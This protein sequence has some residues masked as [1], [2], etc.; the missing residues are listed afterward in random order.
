MRTL[1]V[2]L[3]NNGIVS[4]AGAEVMPL[5]S[6]NAKS[7]Y[8]IIFFHETVPFHEDGRKGKSRAGGSAN[9]RLKNDLYSTRE[10]LKL[11]AN[12]KDKA[13]DELKTANEEIQSS[14][15]ELRSANEELETSK[16]EL[17]SANEEMTTINEELKNRNIDLGRANSDLNN[18][19]G[20]LYTPVLV[21]GARL[22]IRH[23]TPASKDLFNLIPS[24]IGRP[25]K[26]I[27]L[28]IDVPNLEGMIR[29]VIDSLNPQEVEV[30]DRGGKW[31]LLRV[32]PYINKNAKAEG[33][34]LVFVDINAIKL[35]QAAVV[36]LAKYPEQNPGPV[37]RISKDG[38]LIYAN[39]SSGGL[40]EAWGTKVN[41]IVPQNIQEAAAR[42]SETL[43]TC[44]IEIEYGKAVYQLTFTP[45]AEEGYVNV[46]GKDITT[47]KKAEEAL[48]ASRRQN[49]FLADILESSSQPFAIGY[50]DGKLGLMNK[51]FEELSGYAKAELG[52]IDWDKALTPAEWHEIER[53]KLE[54]LHKTG[55]SVRY[56]K[57]Y[58]RRDGTRVPVELLVHLVKDSDGKP[59]YYYS[60]VTDITG[61]KRVAEEM[62]YLKTEAENRA[63]E[64]EAT[65]SSAA[66]GLIIY[67][68]NGKALRMNKAA[69]D[70]LPQEL[71]FGATLNERSRKL[72]WIKENGQPFPPDEI[73]VARALRGETT[74]NVILGIEINGR[75][76][77]IS[78]SAA[79]IRTE[80]GNMLGVVAS[81][82]DISDQKSMEQDLKASEKSY[83]DLI[84]TANSIIIRYAPDGTVSYINDF[85]LAFFGYSR[86]EIVGHSIMKMVPDS[87]S[88][89]GADLTRLSEQVLNDPEKFKYSEN[90]NIKKNGERAWIIWANKAIRDEKGALKEILCVGNDI[91]DLKNSENRLRRQAEML[92]LSYEAIFAWEYDGA[93]ISWNNGA[94]QMYGYS[95][96]EALGRVSHELLKT[97]HTQ[98]LN[99]IKE[100]LAKDKT[101]AGELEHTTKDGRTIIVESR[102]QLITD[103]IGRQIVLETNRDITESKQAEEKLQATMQRFYLILSNMQ[104]AVLLV[105]DEDRVEFA[106]QAFCNIFSLKD[107]PES[108]AN[109]TDNEMIE[110]IKD[111]Y[112]DPDAALARIR[113]II[114]LGQPAIGE[115]V[116]MAGERTLLR[117]FIPI[118]F[119]D[120]LYGRLWVHLDITERKKAEGALRESEERFRSLFRGLPYS[121]VVFEKTGNDFIIKEYN[122]AAIKFTNGKMPEYVGKSASEIYKS[123]PDILE[124]FAVVYKN[125]STIN[126]EKNYRMNSTGKE[127]F[128]RI[129][130][131]YI[132]TDKIIMHTED[133]SER[134]YV[135]EALRES[136]QRLKFHFENSP[137]AVVEWDSNY[138]VTQWSAEAER[139][140]GWKRE[141]TIGKPIM[142]LNMIYVDDIP[143]VNRTIERLGSGKEPLVVS[144][145]RNYTKAGDVIECIWYNTVMLDKNGR[146]SSIMSLV[147]D[148]TEKKMAEEVLQRDKDTLEKL[149]IERTKELL[150]KQIELEH[151]RRLF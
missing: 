79:P 8:F 117:N 91:T 16:E 107:R 84:E 142:D 3:E 57:E 68:M 70:V 18:L 47:R 115:D 149:V 119:N 97:V 14:N 118:R 137:L 104:S 150:D 136:E 143:K 99:K 37:M 81:F 133:F 80:D 4:E 105:T 36:E 131:A 94:R 49:E 1:P 19:L 39:K 6:A 148:I 72:L 15:E 45:I 135:E 55:L 29:S 130:V 41:D 42:C 89:T 44:E 113:E 110:K 147:Q 109:L 90:Q 51:A 132:P 30:R 13:V 35:A 28:G 75:K 103:N 50:P 144:S 140:F 87:D 112:R 20:N 62:A 92:N 74:A 43:E 17:Q 63:A 2:R 93:I 24:D 32:R 25:I 33:A 46:Y 73:P 121:T 7:R 139:M 102:H 64:L 108:L 127:I 34:I 22:N 122:E 138:I 134:K 128:V 67:D 96:E 48:E 76:L 5:N 38:T 78:A 124:A 86:E 101:W 27:N 66:T 60:F 10:Y 116:L 129:T 106:N 125:K 61:R 56:E 120:K 23:F 123:D 21:L 59:L 58:I 77:W 95:S 126:I 26:D 151:A 83:R 85:G 145:N 88:V 31:H 9:T 65:I 52:S 12:D 111:R 82:N 100:I 69:R 53:A 40:L 114:S 141:E 71:F 98:G 11:I 146:M 54:E